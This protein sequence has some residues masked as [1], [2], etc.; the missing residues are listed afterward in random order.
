[1]ETSMLSETRNEK[2]ILFY[3][4]M[5]EVYKFFTTRLDSLQ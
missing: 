3:T 1:M 2:D 4:A 5:F